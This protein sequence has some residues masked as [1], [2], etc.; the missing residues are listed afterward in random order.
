M[1]NHY[2]WIRTPLDPLQAHHGDAFDLAER[3][4]R[5]R[6]LARRAVPEPEDSGCDNSC[7]EHGD[8][9]LLVAK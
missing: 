5:G 7:F 8:G 6:Q 2:A 4:D 1:R 3:C 9:Y